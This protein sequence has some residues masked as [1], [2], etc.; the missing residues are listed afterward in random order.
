MLHGVYFKKLKNLFAILKEGDFLF[1]G[2]QKIKSKDELIDYLKV[3]RL[4]FIDEDITVM[5][6]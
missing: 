4:T 2:E 3:R 5:E 1:I 6:R